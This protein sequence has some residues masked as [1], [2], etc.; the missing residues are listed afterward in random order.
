MEKAERAG[1]EA[2]ECERDYYWESKIREE[3]ER[4]LSESNYSVDI[5]KVLTASKGPDGLPKDI[6]LGSDPLTLTYIRNLKEEVRAFKAF[7]LYRILFETLKSQSCDIMF[8]RSKDFDDMRVG[9]AMLYNLGVQENIM[10][11]IE[12]RKV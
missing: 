5:T 7:N 6:Y 8:N 3:V 12:D 11:T 1:K 4:R 2:A 9:K 10:K